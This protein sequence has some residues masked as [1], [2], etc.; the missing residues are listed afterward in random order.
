M[1]SRT[2][3]F[4]L[5]L[6]GLGLVL[7]SLWVVTG[8]MRFPGPW[9]LLPV[10]GTLLLLLAGTVR[11][12]PVTQALALRPI[13]KIGDWSYAIYLWHWP[14]V[15]FAAL[16][17]PHAPAAVPAAA[18]LSVVPAVLSY[19]LIEQ[20]LRVMTGLSVRRTA[21]LVLTVVGVPL[22]LSG[23]LAEVARTWLWHPGL[24]ETMPAS[25]LRPTGWGNP[26]CISRVPLSMRDTTGCQWYGDAP[27]VPIY[28]VGDSNAQHFSDGMIAAA[29]TLQRP[30]TT[31]ANDGC[32]LVDAYLSLASEPSLRS[33]C[34]EGYE[35]LMRWLEEHPPG[36]VVIGS[37]SRYW[38]DS[39]DYVVSGTA[40]VS[41]AD[42]RKN[43]DVLDDGLLRTVRRLQAVGDRVLLLQTIPH[44]LDDQYQPK[45][46]SC[47]GWDVIRDTC[48]AVYAEMP[49]AAA[50][51][52]QSASREG[53][54]EVARKT[55]AKVFDFRKF[56]CENGTCRTRVGQV[57][58]YMPDGY[59]LNRL[60]SLMLA[61]T[62]AAAIRSAG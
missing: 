8:A 19:R 31:L 53:I 24:A 36:L 17:W 30:L 23:G 2:L 54:A 55:G 12:N 37:V 20:P 9:T 57:D 13:V 3:A 10:A 38:R 40:E 34:R 39:D 1:G 7:A 42:P 4:M 49:L 27:G 21:F 46:G 43:V 29:G 5:G 45:G 41:D 48:H 44:Y 52:W 61:E 6:L 35:S 58:F 62:L 22:M 26:R 14:L 59:H 50:D 47:S 18:L 16:L 56:F 25:I 32:P 33:R 11:S 60:G 28:L 15:V 51:A